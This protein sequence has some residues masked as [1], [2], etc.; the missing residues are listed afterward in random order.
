VA[1]KQ[2]ATTAKS[3]K[4]PRGPAGPAG[5]QGAQGLQGPA[6]LLTGPAAGDLTG[7]Y[8]NP[9]I[10]SEAVGPA[11]TGVVPAAQANTNT[12]VSIPSG[13]PTDL[14]LNG[15]RFDYSNMH[16]N[17][18]NNESLTAPIAG[19]YLVEATVS[20]EASDGAGVR[21]IT[22]GGPFGAGDVRP[23]AAPTGNTVTNASA[24]MEFFPGDEVHIVATQT[25]GSAL[26]ALGQLSMI[27]LGPVAP[28]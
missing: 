21:A 24:I 10:A 27:W 15:T 11:E 9:Q 17:V 23:Q 6:G 26:N 7:N 16:S 20:W 4:G 18:T 14:P 13:T 3:K 28:A 5:P 1:T 25:S 19:V 22:V 2:G 8:P 12:E